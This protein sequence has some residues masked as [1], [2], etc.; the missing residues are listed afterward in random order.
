M[1]QHH[2]NYLEDGTRSKTSKCIK[3]T[4][5][6]EQVHF[7]FFDTP[8][9]ND[10]GG[11]LSDN[12]NVDRIFECIQTLQDLTALV[13]VLNGTQARLTV[14]IRNVLERFRDRIPDVVYK[15]II[16]ILTNCASHTVNFG[17]VKL[18]SHAPIFYMQNS[19]FSSDAQTWSLQT[20]EILQRD[21][22][23]SMQT[24]NEFVK[25]LLTLTPVSTETLSEMNDDRNAIRSVLHESRLMIMEL[26]HIEDELTALEQ[27]SN[28]YSANIEKYASPSGQSTKSIQVN[29]IT[30][31]SYHNTICLKCNTVCH[32]RCSL[33][34]TT[35]VGERVFRRCTVIN[36]GRCTVCPGKCSYD[37]HYHDRRL[38]K[39]V[40]KTL[41]VAISA[42]ANKYTEARKDKV[43]CET[44]CETVQETKRLIE[45]SL[46]EQFTKVR[47]ACLRVRK[48]CQGFNVAEE[49]C[50]FVNFLKN[51]INSLRSQTVMKKAAKFV[52]KLETLADQLQNDD[53]L[54]SLVEPLPSSV[55]SP[56]MSP[57]VA[58]KRKTAN[59]NNSN[60]KQSPKTSQPQITSAVVSQKEIILILNN[61]FLFLIKQ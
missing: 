30:V 55:R 5:T 26:Q 23:V 13:L 45:Q 20:R 36:N 47:D 15:N 3:Y 39:S 59:N 46:Q 44:K 35:R 12:E 61:I 27:A 9:I 37:M 7:N 53:S 60:H 17:S 21:W 49:L 51:D 19:A 28:I 54:I 43:A 40:P 48:N 58:A 42:V 11:Y 1:P 22:N 14:N 18:L 41:K 33:T 16:V 57:P 32:E 52:E 50:I 34:E 24:M 2:E 29:E 8:G 10:T 25:T 31:T 38:I 4:Y 6:V 56:A